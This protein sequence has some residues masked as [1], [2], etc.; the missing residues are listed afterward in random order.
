MGHYWSMMS[1]QDRETLRRV[2]RGISA[3]IIALLYL[4]HSF[5]LLFVFPV[6][7]LGAFFFT[8]LYLLIATGIGI[9][10]Y[11]SLRWAVNW[12]RAAI[13]IGSFWAGIVLIGL[14]VFPANPYEPGPFGQM[15]QYSSVF[16]GYPDAIQLDDLYHGNRSERAAARVKYPA[17]AD[18]FLIV[19][20]DG[21]MYWIGIRD[22]V[23][24]D[25]DPGGIE[26]RDDGGD[27]VVL[28]TDPLDPARR[29]ERDVLRADVED[30]IDEV[31][32]VERDDYEIYPGSYADIW[33]DPVQYPFQYRFRQPNPF[34]DPVNDVPPPRTTGD[35]IFEWA[36]RA[37]K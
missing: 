35:A 18:T 25:C 7:S 2:L 8:P 13:V 9:A 27:T 31:I 28:V 19:V 24:V 21:E 26:V 22:G 34:P 15:A 6:D 32:P 1:A 29:T 16:R 20:F 11:F 36:L 3:C 10:A 5:W 33:F 4:G 14:L 30:V 17:A 23:I 37:F 12:K